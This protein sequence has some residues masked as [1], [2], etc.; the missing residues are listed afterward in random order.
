MGVGVCDS[1]PSSWEGETGG[2]RIQDQ[3]GVLETLHFLVYFEIGS[4]CVSQASFEFAVCPRL[5]LSSLC[6]PG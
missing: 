6:I 2:L 5:A 1:G 3:P 4:H